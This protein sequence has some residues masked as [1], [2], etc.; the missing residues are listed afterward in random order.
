MVE[1]IQNE[2]FPIRE[3]N[4]EPRMKNIRLVSLSHLHGLTYEDSDTL[5]FEFCVVC[6]T[7]DYK[8]NENKLKLFPSTLKDASL[9]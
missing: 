9:H 2:I 1:K 8:S 6:R 4:G 3:T 5:M 7:Y